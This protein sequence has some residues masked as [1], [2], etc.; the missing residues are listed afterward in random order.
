MF[1][2]QVYNIVNMISYQNK[3]LL[4]VPEAVDGVLIKFYQFRTPSFIDFDNNAKC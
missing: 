4:D 1:T 3:I 2:A